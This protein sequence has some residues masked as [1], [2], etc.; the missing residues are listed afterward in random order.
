MWITRRVARVV[1]IVRKENLVL[2]RY[3]GLCIKMWNCKISGY[4]VRTSIHRYVPVSILKCVSR[5][6]VR[7]CLYLRFP[8]VRDI[9]CVYAVISIFYI[10]E[11]AYGLATTNTSKKKKTEFRVIAVDIPTVKGEKYI[12]IERSMNHF[13]EW[14][15]FDFVGTRAVLVNLGQRAQYFT[16][17]IFTNNNYPEKINCPHCKLIN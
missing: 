12:L 11:L 14:R 10:K 16:S 3:T 13:G 15:R 8:I 7:E 9:V 1:V 4:P 17:E 5:V 2:H 6:P